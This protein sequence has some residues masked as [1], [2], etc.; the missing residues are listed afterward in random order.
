MNGH[1]LPDDVGWRADKALVA[2]L[3]RLNAQLTK[4]VMRYFDADAGL[5]EPV[6]IVDERTLG[7]QLTKAAAELQARAER[8]AALGGQP[9][10][11]E[12][13]VEPSRHIADGSV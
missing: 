7:E 5:A 1:L 12:G 9:L 8:R 3:S 2:D 11:V 4:Y 10:T 13:D 6:S